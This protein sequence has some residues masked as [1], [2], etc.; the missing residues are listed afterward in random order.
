MPSEF[1]NDHNVL[2]L[3]ATILKVP[4]INKL[5]TTSNAAHKYVSPSIWKQET[6]VSVLYATRSSIN[7]FRLKRNTDLFY[8]LLIYRLINQ[9]RVLFNAELVRSLSHFSSL[10]LLALQTGYQLSDQQFQAKLSPSSCS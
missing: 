6:G 10:F 1:P 2:A 3:S 7:N 8:I 5:P 9:L 4:L